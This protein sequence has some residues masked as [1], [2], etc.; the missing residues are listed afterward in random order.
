MGR[1]LARIQHR[2]RAP[3]PAGRGP[4]AARA[5]VHRRLVRGRAVVTGLGAWARPRRGA[6]FRIHS[7]LPTPVRSPS[8]FGPRC[9]NL[10]DILTIE[11]IKAPLASTD[12]KGAISELVDVLCAC[13]KVADP[14]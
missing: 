7:R 9:M 8:D 10:L 5:R 3:P 13:R 2:P 12:K 14:Q 4:G 11:C 1:P 6:D